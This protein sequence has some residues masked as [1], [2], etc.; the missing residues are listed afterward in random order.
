MF[1][2][3]SLGPVPSSGVRS[4]TWDIWRRYSAQSMAGRS[5]SWRMASGNRRPRRMTTESHMCPLCGLQVIGERMCGHHQGANGDDWHLV[6]R[7]MCDLFHRK[8][9]PKRLFRQDRMEGDF[10]GFSGDGNTIV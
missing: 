7:I 4:E 10:W 2:V 1:P 6:N 3:N 5:G 8:L 9:E